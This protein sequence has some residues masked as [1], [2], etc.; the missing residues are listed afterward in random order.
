M[1]PCLW[2]SAWS[3]VVAFF[4]QSCEVFLLLPRAVPTACCCGI[5][6]AHGARPRETCARLKM[7]PPTPVLHALPTLCTNGAHRIPDGA[8]PL[9]THSCMSLPPARVVALTSHPQNPGKAYFPVIG[10]CPHAHHGLCGPPAPGPGP[11][12]PHLSPQLVRPARGHKDA[13]LPKSGPCFKAA[14]CLWA[15]PSATAA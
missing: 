1:S 6:Q 13:C 9:P 8:P 3:L 4:P 10:C 2:D 11:P 7:A 15:K 5:P 12:Q 14:V